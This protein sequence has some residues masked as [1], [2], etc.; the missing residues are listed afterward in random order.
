MFM[1]ICCT[2]NYYV[3][4]TTLYDLRMSNFIPLYLLSE[5]L[6]QPFLISFRKEIL[7]K[8]RHIGR[9]VCTSEYLNHIHLQLALKHDSDILKDRNVHYQA[10]QHSFPNGCYLYSSVKLF[11]SGG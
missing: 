7:V 6:Y 4:C 2:L 11:K 1:H 5:D 9:T 3:D 10:R 8:S